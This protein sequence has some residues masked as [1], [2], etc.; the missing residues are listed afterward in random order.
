[1]EKVEL[2]IPKYWCWFWQYICTIIRTCLTPSSLSCIQVLVLRAQQLPWCK[3]NSVIACPSGIP[4]LPPSLPP[5]SQT[6]QL[7]HKFG[8][9][10]IKTAVLYS[11]SVR[12]M[13]LL[14][15][16]KHMNFSKIY[17]MESV[18]CPTY[19]FLFPIVTELDPD[20]FV[21]HRR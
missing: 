18:F 3:R 16:S 2:Y 7:S 14:Q 19:F 13:E 6:Q 5:L 21:F 15:N 17:Y 11:N 20:I 10:L 12:S 8:F 4:F 1:M 9:C